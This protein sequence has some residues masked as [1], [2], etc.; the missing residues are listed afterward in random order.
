MFVVAYNDQARKNG[1]DLELALTV[2]RR[3][4]SSSPQRDVPPAQRESGTCNP[5]LSFSLPTF[6][7]S[8]NSS[9]PRY[10]TF[11]ITTSLI[12]IADMAPNKGRNRASEFEELVDSAPKGLSKK[13][14]PTIANQSKN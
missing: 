2:G 6:K 5:N 7:I 13:N 9:R 14:A 8:R 3:S 12:I 11:L 10:Q 1:L 4:S